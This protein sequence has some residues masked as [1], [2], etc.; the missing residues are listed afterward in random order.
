MIKSMTAYARRESRNE[1]GVVVWEIR[2]VNHRYLEPLFKLQDSFRETEPELRNCLYKHLA[3]GKV[4]CLLRVQLDSLS[5]PALKVNM[6][7]AASLNGVLH[8]INRLLDNPAHINAIEILKWPGVLETEEVDMDPVREEIISLFDETLADLVSTREKEGARLKPLIEDRLGAIQVI[9]N[10]V[11]DR[12]PQ[13]IE[14][15]NEALRARFE[16]LDL[17]LDGGRLEQEL[18]VLAQKADVAE[19]LDRLE[20]H[21][22]EVRDVLDR[23]E[24]VGRR[25]DFLMQELNREANTLGSKSLVT[26]TSQMAVELKVIIEQMR[27]QIQ[28]IE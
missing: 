3:R 18:V 21:A 8:Q 11:R 14:R 28:N 17:D 6:E 19:E 16:E 15:Q 7:L 27:E 12:L 25:L 10:K 20:T 5:A 2:S 9:V 4:E 13:I 26:E 24:P 23:H 1:W 22:R